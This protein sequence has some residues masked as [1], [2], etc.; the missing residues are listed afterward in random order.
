MKTLHQ[1]IRKGFTLVEILV[2]V[3][4]IGVL[5][6]VVVPAIT[7][8]VSSGD[9]A[10]IVQDIQGIGSGI[11]RFKVEVRPKFPSDIEDLANAIS[12]TDDKSIDGALFVAADVSRW[13]GPYIESPTAITGTAASSSAWA[14]TGFAASIMNGLVLCSGLEEISGCNPERGDYVA[15]RFGPL[16]SA[17]FELVNKVVDGTET[18]GSSG[19]FGK[20]KLRFDGNLAS[21]NAFFL[22]SPYRQP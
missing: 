9:P 17:Q 7:Q 21:G 6:A 2:T 16:T 18:A 4:V 14:P 19:S 15:I 13:N 5:A 8:Q 12:S 11:E 20:G 3:I 10:R 22:V 1:S